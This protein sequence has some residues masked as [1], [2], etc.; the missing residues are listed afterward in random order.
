MTK[1]HELLAAEATVTSANER[2]LAETRDK[3]K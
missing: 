2:L 3:F 1:L